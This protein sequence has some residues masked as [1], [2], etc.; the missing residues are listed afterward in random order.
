MTVVRFRVKLEDAADA[1]GVAG[2]IEERLGRL[3]AVDEVRAAPER[4]QA[5]GEI[6]IAVTAAA[7]ITRG[8]RD[9]VVALRETIAELRGLVEEWRGF[10]RTLLVEVDGRELDVRQVGEPELAAIAAEDDG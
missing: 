6:V 9:V 7:A 1:A 5:I 4:P 8:G 2:A 10:R 3:E